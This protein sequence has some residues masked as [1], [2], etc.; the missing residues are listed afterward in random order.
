LVSEYTVPTKRPHQAVQ[1]KIVDAMSD[2]Q[3]PLPPATFEFLVISLKTQTE[4]HLGILHFG[5][6]KDRP[7]PDFRIARHN[8]DL[9]A[10]LQEKTRGNCTQEEQRLLDNA[11]TELRFRFVQAMEQ[12]HKK[13]AESAAA[14]TAPETAPE[15]AT[16]Q[17]PAEEQAS[18]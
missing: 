18:E 14:S 10:M 6:E 17:N 3:I 16:A 12:H 5:E 7:E 15:N 8:V 13:T 1:A 4:Y 9:L 2:Q 11:L